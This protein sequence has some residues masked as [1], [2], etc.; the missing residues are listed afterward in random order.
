MSNA[1]RTDD[2]L[3]TRAEAARRLG[4]QPQTLAARECRGKPLLPLVKIG[5]AARY[6]AHDVE[7]LIK[8]CTRNNQSEPQQTS[9]RDGHG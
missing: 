6:R 4:L 2:V 5:R 3:I 1:L 8:S 9:Q 7:N